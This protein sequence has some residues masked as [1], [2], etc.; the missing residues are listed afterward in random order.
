MLFNDNKFV[1]ILYEMHNDYFFETEK[2][3]DA[4]ETTKTTIYDFIERGERTA[5]IVDCENS[6]VYK[7]YATLKNLNQEELQKVKKIILFDDVH[8]T[9]AWSCFIPLLG[10]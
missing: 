2:V 5:I 9:R 6:D 10:Y 7:L 8:T 4:G 3:L 1:N